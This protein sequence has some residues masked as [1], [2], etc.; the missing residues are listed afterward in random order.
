M[1]DS[2]RAGCTGCVTFPECVADNCA[3]A[4]SHADGEEVRRAEY[5]LHEPLG[6]EDFAGGVGGVAAED[7]RMASDCIAL[8]CHVSP[9]EGEVRRADQGK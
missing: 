7:L 9:R 8:S 3:R 2:G 4:R 5:L 6:G 1:T